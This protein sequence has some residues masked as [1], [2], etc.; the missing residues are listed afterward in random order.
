[1]ADDAPAVRMIENTDEPM[2][3]PWPD[4]CGVQGGS[5][6]V[7]FHQGGSYRTAF[8]EVFPA[9]T[10]LRGEGVT[11]A[12]AEDACWA[13]YQVLAKCPH[14]QGF[15]R[16]DYVNGSGFCLRC[17]IWFGR[18]V[19]GFAPLPEY[20]KPSKRRTLLDL[21]FSDPDVALDVIE[22]VARADELPTKEEPGG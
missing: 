9:G 20:Y 17:G 15:E 12:D 6:G 3:H 1:M 18:S 16:R 22:V 21:A 8:V 10:F 2:R 14:D 11:I 5:S 7:V 13:K 4:G 19:T